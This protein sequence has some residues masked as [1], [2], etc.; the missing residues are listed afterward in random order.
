MSV[1]RRALLA[2]QVSATITFNLQVAGINLA[3]QKRVVH[4]HA[5]GTFQCPLCLQS[6]QSVQS[7]QKH[8]RK[9]ICRNVA[10][11]NNFNDNI[12]EIPTN[13]ENVEETPI[14]NLSSIQN[15]NISHPSSHGKMLVLFIKKLYL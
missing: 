10:G 15:Q 14:D 13:G 1:R 5:N 11:V 8:A 9:G 12:D 4:K 7:I 3:N 6:F 2:E